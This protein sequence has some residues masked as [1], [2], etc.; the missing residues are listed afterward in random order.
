[1]PAPSSTPPVSE[2]PTGV[3]VHPVTCLPEFRPGD[4]LAGAIATAAP[5]LTD[6]DVVVVT[7]KGHENK[8]RDKDRDNAGDNSA[9]PGERNAWSRPG[10]LRHPDW[11]P[12]GGGRSGGQPRPTDTRSE[13]W[14]GQ[15]ASGGAARRPLQPSR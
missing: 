12:Y 4:D 1:L 15:S 2:P 8:S 11:S 6:G 14:G 3:S 5:W 9:A 13:S 7:F 10:M